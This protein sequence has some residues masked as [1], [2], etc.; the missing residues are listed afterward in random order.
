MESWT[1]DK[2]VLAVRE[3]DREA[4]SFL[5]ARYEK[6]I[7]S[8]AYRLTNNREEAQDLGQEA[9]LKIYQSLDHYQPGRSFFS[10]MYKVASNQ[11]Y[12]I[13]RKRKDQETPLEEVMGFVADKETTDQ[14]PEEVLLEE[15]EKETLN[16]ALTLLPDKYRLTLILRY[17]EEMTYQ[18][19][20]DTLDI[21]LSA[22]ESRIHRAKKKLHD[23][24]Q[25]KDR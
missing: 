21:S 8:L 19:I 4:F 13:L 10:W 16:Q 6:Q 11:C 2:L 15:E 14:L 17:M 24:Y 18:E 9:F 5:I 3:G 22:V 12:S 23:I 7:Y 20:A 25:D 1:D